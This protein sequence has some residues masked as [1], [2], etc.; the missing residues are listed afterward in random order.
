MNLET[1]RACGEVL[2]GPRWQQPLARALKVD[3]RTVRRWVAGQTS[4]PDDLPS[5]LLGVLAAKR[6]AIKEMQ[7]TIRWIRN[8]RT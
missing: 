6:S 3:D 8:E 4:M 1:L 5:R 7:E 2:Y